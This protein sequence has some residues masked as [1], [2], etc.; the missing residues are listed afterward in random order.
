MSY[1]FAILGGGAA[2][3]S[4]ALELVRSP[5]R[6]QSI[7][8]VEKDAKNS[9]DRTWCYWT[10]APTPFDRIARR[11]WSRLRFRSDSLER[12]WELAPYRYQMVRGLDFYNYARAG[13]EKHN[14]TFLRGA[15][16][17]EDGPEC[18]TVSVNGQTFQATW[19]F[20]SRIRPADMTEAVRRYN[21]LKQHFTGW[22]IE[23]DTPAFDPQTVTM[24][25]LC[26]PQRDGV[27]FFYIL[28]FS[29][30]NAL[31]EYTLFSPA[32]LPEGEYDQALS[33]YL[34]GRLGLREYRVLEREHGM[35]P[36]TDR[37]FPRRLG[38]RVLAIGTRGGRVKPSTGYAF[39][40]IQR[41]SQR[42]VRSLVRSGHPFGLPP[43][44]L[45]FRLYDAVI[46]DVFSGEPQLGRPILSSIFAK[47]PVRRVL[48]FL[49][50]R[51]SFAEDLRLLSSQPAGPFL[52]AIGRM[53]RRRM[54][55]AG[56]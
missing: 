45:R 43:D 48:E 18:A 37:P 9:N 53:I 35:I 56:H 47:N 3:L 29:P 4:L 41:D 13:L 24:F 40:R 54:T 20:D 36:M 27:T 17:V 28:P 8:I 30:T 31:V 21:S 14:V 19:A 49:D 5:L 11:T 22:E 16:E 23:T 44:P 10:D 12:T 50:D 34:A 15:G 46:L 26:T 32:L 1:D 25:D 51:S 2:G 39:T 42:I 6:D 38:R 55:W 7:L 33:S 52:R